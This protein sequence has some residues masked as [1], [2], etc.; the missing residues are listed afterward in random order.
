MFIDDFIERI[1]INYFMDIKHLT[2][3]IQTYRDGSF[4]KAAKN[5]YI[6]PQGLSKAIKTLEQELKVP[7]F[8]R[9]Q[10]GI[11]PTEY[12][13]YLYQH[14]EP[15]VDKLKSVLNHLNDMVNEGEKRIS[16]GF[17][18]GIINALSSDFISSFQA[19]YPNV[20]LYV[21]ENGDLILEE[22]VYNEEVDLAFVIGPVN[23]DKFDIYSIKKEDLC[24]LVNVSHPLSQKTS[25]NFTDLKNHNISIINDNFKLYH[26]FIT[27]CKHSGFKP[28]ITFPAADILTVHQ[29]SNLNK[30]I[31]ISANFVVDAVNYPNVVSIPF[32]D[33]TFSWEIYLITKKDHYLSKYVVEFI[34]HIQNYMDRL[35]T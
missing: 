3:F 7:L 18:S 12:G 8:Y 4:S 27:K 15:L 13:T 17:T 11:K 25:I 14:F 9:S 5:L 20:E 1:G 6:T 19:S 30:C 33:T 31:G 26:N 35:N 24:V 10:R 29:L 16:A 22:A 23:R 32:D 2:Y 21:V 34:N 28:K